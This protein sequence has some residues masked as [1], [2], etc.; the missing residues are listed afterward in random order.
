MS[1]QA[2]SSHDRDMHNLHNVMTGTSYLDRALGVGEGI[3]NSPAGQ[4][5]HHMLEHSAP[6]LVPFLGSVLGPLGFAA[7]A[8]ETIMGVQHA[9]H[10]SG[11]KQADGVVDALKGVSGMVSGAGSTLA[12]LGAF[13]AAGAVGTG[14]A[15][16]GLTAGA[17][18]GPLAAAAAVGL[19]TGSLISHHME[20]NKVGG[21]FG[22]D[23]VGH[24]RDASDWGSDMGIGFENWAQS[25]LGIQEG[26][27]GFFNTLGDKTF[28]ALG[29]AAATILGTGAT[30]GGLGVEALQGMWGLAKRA[31]RIP[32]MGPPGPS[33]Y[34]NYAD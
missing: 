31:S 13:P 2:M 26:G 14:F 17:A 6:N 3:L 20:G 23:D 25:G 34:Q 22:K 32:G 18:A 10:N 19:G 1:E 24:Q 27:D 9:M 11:T 12:A 33:P 7:G 30:M 4:G 21:L 15:G 16:T 8:G 29:G 28:G 5:L